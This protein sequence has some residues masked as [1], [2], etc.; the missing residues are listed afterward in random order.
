MTEHDIPEPERTGRVVPLRAV[1]AQTEVRLDEDQ[2]AAPSY[3]DLTSPDAQ[4]KAV[5][6]EHWR[7]RENARRHVALAAARHGHAAAY[8]SVRSPAYFF[9]A[10]GFAVRGVIVTIKRLITWWH[11]PGTAKLEGEAAAN[12]LLTEHLRLNKQGREVRKARG[13]IL[14]LCLAGIAVVAVAAVRFAPWWGW[15]LIAAASFAL[16]ALAGRPQG[17][18][19]TTRAQIP[20]QVQPPTQDVIF[21]ALGSVGI[22][23]ISRALTDGSMPPLPAPVREDGPGWRA[24]VDLPYGVTATQVI[25]RREALASGLR[26]PLGAVWPEP[27]THE[28]AGRLELWVGRED[29]SKAKPPPWPWLR[30]GGGNVFDP[31]PFGSSPRGK[32]VGAPLIEHNWLIGSMPGQGKALALDTPVPTPTGWTTMGELRAGDTV[33]GADGR[34]CT[35]LNAWPVRHDRPCYEVEF[36]D[37]TV[38]VADADH[39]WEVTTRSGRSNGTP[40]VVLSTAEM[41]DSVY[42][43]ADRRTNYSVRVTCPLQAPEAQLPVPPYVLGAWLGDGTSANNGFTSADTEILDQIRLAG[44]AV[45]YVG[46]PARPYGYRLGDTTMQITAD[47]RHGLVND[48]ANSL[49]RF[50]LTRN[51]HIPVAYLRASEGQRRELLA[52]LLDTDGYCCPWGEVQFSVT[53]ERLARDVRHLV[54]SLGY[55]CNIRSKRARVNGKDCGT[56]WIVQ[57]TPADKVFRLSRKVARQLTHVRANADRRFITAIRPI[58]SVPVRCITVDSPDALYLVGE[59]CIPTHN[60]SAVR[61]LLSGAALDPTCELWVHELKGT[62]DLD[63]SEQVSHRFVSGIDDESIGYAAGSLKLLRLEVMRRTE[64]IK[65]L[66]RELNQDKKITREIANRRALKLHPLICIIDEAQN[67]F[68]HDKFGKQAGEDA[69]FIIKIGRALGVVLILATQRPDRDSLPTGV[70]GNVSIRFCLKVP[71]QVEN[72]MVLGTSAYKNGA[73]ATMFRPKVDAGL[74]YL[75]DEESLPHVVRTY[76]LNAADAERVAK[77]ARA[78][79]QAAGTLSG[80]ALGEDDSEPQ[81]DVL[82][83]VLDVFAGD[84]GLQWPALAERLEDRFPERWAGTT[85]E[86]VSAELRARGVRSV[87]VKTDGRVLKGCRLADV[88]KAVTE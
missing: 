77:R 78:L 62:G 70:S 32:R 39:L 26:R 64:R 10:L 59:T 75:K 87:D 69:V 38:I 35:V 3:V 7:T 34:P 33:F 45:T 57:F 86:V 22:A 47:S 85:A 20:A 24:E 76:Y 25:E 88:E 49:R 1:D 66:P 48:F 67:L 37:G 8:H 81:R 83:D 50:G 65:A 4:R 53:S 5:I 15:A 31:L 61:V 17:K 84:S 18:T 72:D 19:I 60:T 30:T 42:V 54:A 68:A 40:H 9:K 44:V 46:T 6:P 2:A 11:I 43:A 56:A 41:A 71:G 12:G 21:R 80:A 55:K 13:T 58:S 51:K 52:G 27:V 16:F 73:R 23:Q 28:H 29:V 74:G 79:R 36:S 82:A 63:S 14:A